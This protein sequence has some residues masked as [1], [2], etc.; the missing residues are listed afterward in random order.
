MHRMLFGW[1]VKLSFEYTKKITQTESLYKSFKVKEK[2][3][4]IS[5]H[6]AGLKMFKY[7]MNTILKPNS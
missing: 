5:V 2:Q 1:M 7:Q 3:I 6:N 4:Q